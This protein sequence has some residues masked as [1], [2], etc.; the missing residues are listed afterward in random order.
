MRPVRLVTI[1]EGQG[2]VIA[3]PVLVRAWF[4]HAQVMRPI[5]VP[6]ERF[7][8]NPTYRN[9]VFDLARRADPDAV[10]VLLDAHGA[11]GEV[12]AVEA[13]LFAALPGCRASLVVA[14]EEFEA[15]FL[16]AGTAIGLA[17]DTPDAENI[18]GAKERLKRILGHYRPTADQ[19]SLTARLASAWPD[20]D[21]ERRVPSLVR[22]HTE[23]MRLTSR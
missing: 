16:A 7:L 17:E 12:T 15:W 9:D 18:I 10:L 14:K 22:L 3:L 19:A 4:P 20:L 21:Q 6:R 8:R 1:V 23:L 5:L 13:S 11:F 2:E